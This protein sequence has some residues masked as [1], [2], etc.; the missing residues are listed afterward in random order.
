M[1]RCGVGLAAGPGLLPGLLEPLTGNNRTQPLPP[2]WPVSATVGGPAAELDRF[3]AHAAVRAC[4]PL[5]LSK[6][7]LAQLPIS[8]GTSSAGYDFDLVGRSSLTHS[9]VSGRTVVSQVLA[10]SLIRTASAPSCSPRTPGRP[11]LRPDLDGNAHRP[12]ARRARRTHSPADPERSSRRPRPADL[13]D[14]TW[15]P[16]CRCPG[17]GVS[18]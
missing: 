13:P 16:G 17:R 6:E 8:T 9:A 3:T 4:A 2:G 14:V 1:P 18:S 15:H 11:R 7:R 5:V 10:D 12:S